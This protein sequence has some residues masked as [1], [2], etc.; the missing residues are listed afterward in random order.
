MSAS[1]VFQSKGHKSVFNR[2]FSSNFFNKQMCENGP[3]ALN[4]HSH[5]GAEDVFLADNA[6][7]K[8]PNIAEH[9]F[10]ALWNIA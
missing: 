9:V 2:F 3:K 4:Q 1:Y 7:D 8:L 5:G 6:G 10:V